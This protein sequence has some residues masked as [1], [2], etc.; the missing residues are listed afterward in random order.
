MTQPAAFFLGANSLNFT[1]A[2]LLL[3]ARTYFHHGSHSRCSLPPG[4]AARRVCSSRSPCCLLRPS[5]REQGLA[6]GPNTLP[7]NACNCGKV[8]GVERARRAAAIPVEAFLLAHSS[9]S[10]RL[11]CRADYSG[12]KT[13]CAATLSLEQRCSDCGCALAESVKSSLEAEGYKVGPEVE[14]GWIGACLRSRRCKKVA[15]LLP[16]YST[17]RPLPAVSFRRHQRSQPVRHHP[18]QCA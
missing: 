1:V 6:R 10:L 18:A 9:S 15:H 4:A 17:G 7:H 8:R 11:A 5:P 13:K 2:A 14:E 3:S 12:I 16:A